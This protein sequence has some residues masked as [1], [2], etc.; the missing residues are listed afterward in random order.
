LESDIKELDSQDLTARKARLVDL[1]GYQE[2]SVVSRTIVDRE[3][4]TVTLFAFDE[5]QG[6]SEHTAPYDAM[7]HVL[8]GA[9]DIVISGKTHRLKE[10]EMI[11]M[12][13]DQPHSLKA[14]ERFKMMLIMIRS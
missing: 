1:V 13:A 8:D 10:G 14:P 9:A 7:V 2:G 3:A 5:R 6:L 4:G 12:P 11:I